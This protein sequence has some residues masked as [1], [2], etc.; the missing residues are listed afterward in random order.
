MSLFGVCPEQSYLGVPDCSVRDIST[1]GKES[2]SPSD[3]H[4]KEHALFVSP[5]L[6]VSDHPSESWVKEMRYIYPCMK[7]PLLTSLD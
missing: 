7:C 6:N 3:L 5:G 1:S 4:E 2:M